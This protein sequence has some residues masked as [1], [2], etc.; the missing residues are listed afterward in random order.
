LTFPGEVEKAQLLQ[1]RCDHYPMVV[2][3]RRRLETRAM[4]RKGI[5]ALLGYQFLATQA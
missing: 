4:M 5:V 2:V 3:L 1:V